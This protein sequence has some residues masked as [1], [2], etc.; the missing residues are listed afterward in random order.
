MKRLISLL[1]LFLIVTTSFAQEF[2]AI[3]SNELKTNKE[4]QHSEINNNKLL[5]GT[6]NNSA[7][8]SEN[9]ISETGINLSA[10][11]LDYSSKPV[12]AIKIDFLSPLFCS[13]EFTFEQSA[14]LGKSWEA[15][16]GIIGVGNDF[17]DQDPFGV[18]GK[19]SYKIMLFPESRVDPRN[20]LRGIYF[21]PE[22]NLRTV[23]YDID[24]SGDRENQSSMAFMVRFGRQWVFYESFLV[25]LY[26]GI[27]YGFNSNDEDQ[28]PYGFYVAS[29]DFPIAFSWGL[30]FGWAF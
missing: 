10:N 6:D 12:R 29:D 27:G 4:E 22:I 11:Q 26:G 18:Y 8:S 7:Y 9:K 20:V 19:F 3:I 2:G 28:L 13:L 16:L 24:D 30:R 25:D 17:K 1:S 15:S 5:L 14:R 21:A 23:S